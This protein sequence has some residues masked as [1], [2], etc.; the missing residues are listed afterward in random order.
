[1]LFQGPL[2]LCHRQSDFV[3]PLFAMFVDKRSDVIG[4]PSILYT[5]PPLQVFTQSMMRVHTFALC[6]FLHPL[7]T[8]ALGFF[9][10]RQDVLFPRIHE[11]VLSI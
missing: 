10:H 2:L 9:V 5:L 11:L 7:G 3:F 8:A 4:T 1:M 6:L